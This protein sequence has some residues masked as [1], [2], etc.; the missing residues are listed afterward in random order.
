MREGRF[1]A[2]RLGR[3]VAQRDGSLHV[4]D[5]GADGTPEVESIEDG[6]PGPEA[7]YLA[8]EQDQLVREAVARLR[9]RVGDLGWDIIQRRLAQESPKT[10]TEIGETWGFSRERTRQVEARTLD[11]LRRH[12]ASLETDL[13]CTAA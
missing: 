3:R 5:A 11:L 13:T 4:A 8:A 9:R 2:Q 6:A 7:T 10:L 1:T 12:L